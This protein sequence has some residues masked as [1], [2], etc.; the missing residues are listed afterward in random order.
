MT[1]LFGYVGRM[2][3]TF[4]QDLSSLAYLFIETL[5]QTYALFSDRKRLKKSRLLLHVDEAGT[6]SL[7]LVIV[8]ASLLGARRSGV[9]TIRVQ[10]R[11]WRTPPTGGPPR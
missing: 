1:N 6:H 5:K 10:A 11:A 8:V 7:M 4:L 9:Y 2:F 3:I